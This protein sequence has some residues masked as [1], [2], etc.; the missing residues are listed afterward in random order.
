MDK[1]IVVLGAGAVGGYVGGHLS[2][3]GEDVL[4]I[5]P[6]PE[7]IEAIKTD[8]LH[9]SNP[10]E[11]HVVEVPCMHL[12]EVQGLN[13]NPVDIAIISTKSYDTEWAAALI[14]PYL[15]PDGF[16]VSLQNSINEERIAGIVGWGKV[17]GCIPSGI[18]VEL[19]KPGHIQR[20]LMPAGK[21]K[22]VFR[23]GEVHGRVTRRVE[24]LAQ[25]LRV[26]DGTK[27]TTNLWG[28]RWTKLIVNSM[29][30]AVS[31]VTGLGSRLIA[32]QEIPRKLSIKI[33]CETIRVGQALGYEIE[34]VRGMDLETLLAA[35]RDESRALK[36]VHR[37]MLEGV[38][39]RTA[40]GRPSTAQDIDKGRRTEIDFINGLVVRKGH[41]AGVPTPLNETITRVVKR[42]ESGELKQHPDHAHDILKSS[43]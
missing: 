13:K 42:V 33:G 41:E 43:V 22:L 20:T 24:D 3:A 18:S 6:W 25:R 5:D 31:A 16:I 29:N 36:E 12:H 28:E 39:H 34:V 21:G 23:L 15:K 2:L 8:G 1:K 38:K 4:L 32:E 27:T 11:E 26:V 37:V 30:N 40:A 19:Y 35:G 10:A 14:K 17:V 7:H 9:L